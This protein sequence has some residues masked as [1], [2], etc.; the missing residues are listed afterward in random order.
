M[1]TA[2]VRDGWIGQIIDGRYALLQ[3]L[4]GTEWSDVFLTE[5]PERG[6][7]K[8][9]IKLIL[10]DT[11]QAEVHV[12]GWAMAT[13][14]SH[15]HLIRLLHTGSCQID[16]T[17]LVY[18][19]MEYAEEDLS[20]IIPDRPLTRTEAREMLD[21]VL[22]ALSYLHQKG[23]V[24]GHLKPSNIMVVDNRLKL[25]CDSLH[26]SGKLGIPFLAPTIYD[27]PEVATGE[28]SPAADIWSLGVTLVEALTQHPPVWDRPRQNE[29]VLPES[30]PQP[31]AD[32]AHECLRSDPA[33]RC[34]LSDVKAR[35]EPARSLPDPVSRTG[36]TP[37]G[38]HGVTAFIGAGLFLLAV[39]VVLKL[40]SHE[41]SQPEPLPIATQQP[42][43]A[44]A[45]PP[46][47]PD[48]GTQP[49]KGVTKG[50]V[51][52]RVQPD[53][54]RSASK[55]IQGRVKVRIRV[56]VDLSGN[57][58]NAM[59][60]SPGPSK[61]FANQ[62]MQAAHQWKFKPAEVDGQAVPSVWVLQFQFGQTG[63]EIT[64]VEASP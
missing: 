40:R 9:A 26:A 62:A 32:I 55:T 37:R 48:Q 31:F 11:P 45:L 46:Q 47:S 53:V 57:V 63:T 35:L 51:A 10:A 54:S 33:R 13:S 8:A 20:Q 2:E 24:H 25:S 58:S 21:P 34:T 41:T 50:A 16:T 15:P 52:K 7:Q 42:A 56:T 28:I 43:S 59:F 64:P 29:P 36:R 23:V 61:Y 22:E 17:R 44:A 38:K 3:W 39:I 6:S 30:V 18:A 4:G 12:A 5:L 14:L 49:S 1:T 19:V 60:D 27:A